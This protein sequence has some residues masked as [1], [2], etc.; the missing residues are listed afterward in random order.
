MTT[1][2]QQNPYQAPIQ[3]PQQPPATL[4][5]VATTQVVP[6]APPTSPINSNSDS[7]E[8]LREFF[9]WVRRWPNWATLKLIIEL[10]TILNT[11]INNF[12][13]LEVLYIGISE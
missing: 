6:P 5:P 2:V 1:K 7:E 3:A 4:T 10:K 9:N 12:Y 8:R 13:D 11:L